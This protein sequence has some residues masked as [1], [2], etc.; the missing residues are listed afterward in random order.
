[1]GGR[2]AAMTLPSSLVEKTASTAKGL[3][4]FGLPHDLGPSLAP[5]V[6]R[7]R[8]YERELVLL[9]LGG[10]CRPRHRSRQI[11]RPLDP[12]RDLEDRRVVG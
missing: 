10:T 9:R 12:V 8:S 11:G 5:A 1:M 7:S 4:R 6:R 2:S 3:S